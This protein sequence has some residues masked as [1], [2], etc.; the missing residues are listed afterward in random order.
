MSRYDLGDNRWGVRTVFGTA[1]VLGTVLII[2]PAT[3][4]AQQQNGRAIYREQLRVR[5]DEQDPEKDRIGFDAGGWATF[6]LFNFDDSLGEKHTLRQFEIRGWASL[7]IDGIHKFYIRGMTG[8]DDWNSGDNTDPLHGDEDTDPR[9]ERAWYELN[10]GRW[11]SG[12]VSGV[13]PPWDVKLKVGRA[14]ADIGTAL[15]LSMP[16]DMIRFDVEAGDWAFMAMLGKTVPWVPNIDAS[17]DIIEHQKRCFYGFELAYTGLDNH[18]PFAYFLANLDRSSPVPD[19]PGQDY[20]YTSRYLGV[21]SE[22]RAFLPRLRYQ[23]EVVGEWGR[24]YSHNTVSGQDD[25]CAMAADVMLEYLFDA[26]TSPKVMVEYLYASGDSDRILNSSSTIGGNR[27]G[28]K[29][30]AFNAFGF[31]DTGIAFAP[32]ISNLHTY[33]FGASCFPLEGNRLF[34]KME[35]GSKV[36]FYHKDKSGGP[37]S[38]TVANTRE[39]WVGWEWDVFCDWRISSD[40]IWTIRYGAFRPGTAFENQ[41]CRQFLFTALTYSF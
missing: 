32:R 33:I 26:R 14:F 2:A 12:Q 20:D 39:Q 18:R 38:D 5:L 3:G 7:N 27:R 23:V 21:G 15:V 1:A 25:I 28:T 40:L 35:F 10:L 36:F 8:W 11:L 16:L 41:E 31:R 9:I 4:F 34:E 6:G 29:D 22:G 13:K 37:I 24:T 17:S 30:R 19:T